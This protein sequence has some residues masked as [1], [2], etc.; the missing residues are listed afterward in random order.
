MTFS[1]GRGTEAKHK[2]MWEILGLI[3]EEC[4]DKNWMVLEDF[5][6]ALCAHER[7]GPRVG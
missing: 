2:L 4:K 3:A 1:Y 6:E 7:Q 5:N